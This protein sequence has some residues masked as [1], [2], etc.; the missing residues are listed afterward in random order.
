MAIIMNSVW[1]ASRIGL[2]YLGIDDP[3][4]E[5]AVHETVFKQV[6][7]PS[8]SYICQ[9]CVNRYMIVD[10]WQ[11]DRFQTILYRILLTI[12]S[13]LT[14]FERDV[15]QEWKW[16][17]GEVQQMWKKVHRML[18]MEGI[19]DVTIH[20]LSQ[21]PSIDHTLLPTLALLA[22]E[23]QF[24]RISHFALAIACFVLCPSFSSCGSTA[25][26][27][28]SN[29]TLQ[30]NTTIQTFIPQCPLSHLIPSRRLLCGLCQGRRDRIGGVLQ[31]VS[32]LLT[33]NTCTLS[34]L[35]SSCNC[36]IL[37]ALSVRWMGVHSRCGWVLAE[38]KERSPSTPC[39]V[40][41]LMTQQNRSCAVLLERLSLSKTNELHSCS[42]SFELL[43]Q[44]FKNLN[45]HESLLTE[46]TLDFHRTFTSI[47]DKIL[48]FSSAKSIVS[49]ERER[50]EEVFV[51]VC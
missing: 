22:Y 51:D 36:D 45:P 25:K 10:G 20:F 1:F 8:E 41:Q 9:V 4:E 13:C 37:C 21:S 47:L 43:S 15:K 18:R 31:S 46:A 39:L 48:R 6:V 3:D 5:R 24:G 34:P 28:V 38:Q 11:S 17:G 27:R 49:K 12:T 42:D 14:Y 19:E 35:D 7:V 2:D 16:E 23:S 26:C 29:L 44:L 50:C 40:K 30:L 32:N 33:P